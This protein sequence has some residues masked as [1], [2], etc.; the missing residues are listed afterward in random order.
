M[1]GPG[2]LIGVGLR[3]ADWLNERRSLP[4]SSGGR[5]PMCNR[6]TTSGGNLAMQDQNRPADA[7]CYGL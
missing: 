4:P 1:S 6:S 7:R 2:W 3:P 5:Q